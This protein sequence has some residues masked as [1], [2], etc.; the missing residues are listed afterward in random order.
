MSRTVCSGETVITAGFLTWAI[1]QRTCWQYRQLLWV[2]K[3]SFQL[4]VTLHDHR[5]ILP[6]KS[7][8]Y[9]LFAFLEKA[10]GDFV[11]LMSHW[12]PFFSRIALDVGKKLVDFLSWIW[13]EPVPNHGV[14]VVWSNVISEHMWSGQVNFN[15]LVV[16]LWQSLRPD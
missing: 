6:Q 1:W 10:V 11:F 9:L 8:G 16:G 4:L 14:S 2:L 7:I 5:G 12:W 3:V 15:I 13:A